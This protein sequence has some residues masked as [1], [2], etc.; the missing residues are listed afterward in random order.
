M[1]ASTTCT[2]SHPVASG[3]EVVAKL[4]IDKPGTGA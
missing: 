4:E 1:K 3:H 2:H